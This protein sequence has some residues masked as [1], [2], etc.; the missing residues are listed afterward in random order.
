ME[1]T[2]LQNLAAIEQRV[3]VLSEQIEAPPGLT[4]FGYAIG[5]ATPY[6][7]VTDRYHWILSERGSEF[8]RQSTHDLDELLYWTFQSIT[9]RMACTFELRNRRANEDLRRQ[10]FAKQEEL[11]ARLSPAWAERELADHRETVRQHP[12]KDEPR[13]SPAV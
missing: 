3:K 5:D 8:H 10:L 9:F 7:E 13:R 1:Q 6:I 2:G 11:L 12:F 4:T